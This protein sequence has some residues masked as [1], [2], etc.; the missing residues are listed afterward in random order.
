LLVL[1]SYHDAGT[2]TKNKTGRMEILAGCGREVMAIV[3]GRGPIIVSPFMHSL[4]E[5]LE[6]SAT[7][8]LRIAHDGAPIIPVL[9]VPFR[10]SK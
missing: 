8:S 2:S 9:T 5:H 1:D 7:R 3:P 6:D 10:N 4:I